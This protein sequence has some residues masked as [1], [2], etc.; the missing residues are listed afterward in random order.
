[1]KKTL[2]IFG[3]YHTLMEFDKTVFTRSPELLVVPKAGIEVFL[4]EL[5][6][7]KKMDKGIDFYILSRLEQRFVESFLKK[8]NSKDIFNQQLSLTLKS[9]SIT[10]KIY[11]SHWH[12]ILEYEGKKVF[13]IEGYDKVI[14]IDC[15]K[16]QRLDFFTL[17]SKKVFCRKANQMKKFREGLWGHI[18]PKTFK[19]TLRALRK[20]LKKE[21][22]IRIM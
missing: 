13:E 3:L 6:K 12:K 8:T 11:H 18:Y 10:D 22:G 21:K 4:N 20:M 5:R 15:D 14:L 2:V 7:I 17:K 16:I 19:V 9:S 1:M